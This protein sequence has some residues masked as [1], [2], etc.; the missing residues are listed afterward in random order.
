MKSRDM[1]EYF[2]TLDVKSRQYGTI[3][4]MK[5]K[6]KSPDRCVL[7]ADT[8][9]STLFK[10]G[11]CLGNPSSSYKVSIYNVKTF[12]RFGLG[13]IPAANA[14]LGR[15]QSS[16]IAPSLCSNSRIELIIRVRASQSGTSS[17]LSIF[18]R[19][20]LRPGTSQHEIHH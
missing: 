10:I 5:T 19:T 1:I 12:M 13:L 3:K 15:F 8:G 18:E 17:T 9:I 20:E 14:P 6:W 7:V 11:T 2:G 4:V 16:I